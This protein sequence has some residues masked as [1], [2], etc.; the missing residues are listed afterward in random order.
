MKRGRGGPIDDHE[1]YAAGFTF[2]CL[3]LSYILGWMC[4]LLFFLRLSTHKRVVVRAPKYKNILSS[5]GSLCDLS[6][7]SLC[8][9][10]YSYSCEQK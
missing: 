4:L 2:F 8:V 3:S 5:P 9:S 10:M 1:L 7:F 6:F